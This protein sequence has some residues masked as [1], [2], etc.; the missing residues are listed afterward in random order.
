MINAQKFRLSSWAI[1][2]ID[3]DFHSFRLTD[4]ANIIRE[5]SLLRPIDILGFTMQF[6]VWKEQL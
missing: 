4:T 3:L 1:N 2:L 5:G 6:S